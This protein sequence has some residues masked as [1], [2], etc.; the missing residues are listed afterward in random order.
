M[1][2]GLGEGTGRVSAL[3]AGRERI[4]GLGALCCKLR[5]GEDSERGK[6]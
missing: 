4:W 2:G 1:V 6:G 3:P 5:R